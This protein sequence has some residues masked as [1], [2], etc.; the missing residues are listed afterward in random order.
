MKDSRVLPEHATGICFL[1]YTIMALSFTI[2]FS[3]VAAI[4]YAL[5]SCQP[6][7]GTLAMQDFEKTFPAC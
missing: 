6:L 4:Y 2:E 5:M 3:P 1:V 7:Q